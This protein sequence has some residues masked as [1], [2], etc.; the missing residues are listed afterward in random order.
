MP[1]VSSILLGV[2]AATAI[3]GTASSIAGASSASDMQQ[4]AL[5]SQE[6]IQAAQVRLAQQ[7]DAR[8]SELH[9]FWKSNYADIEKEMADYLEGGPGNAWIETAKE[10]VPTIHRVSENV[11]DA[12]VLDMAGRGIEADANGVYGTTLSSIDRGKAAEIASAIN[13]AKREGKT[14]WL[15]AASNLASIGR[16]LN[17]AGI[18]AGAS[19]QSGMQGAALTGSNILNNATSTANQ[20]WG[21]VQQGVQGVLNLPW[22]KWTSSGPGATTTTQ[23]LQA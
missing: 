20:A 16:G 8:A 14:E 5:D 15:Q 6:A 1:A 10:E 3:A 18:N 7:Q 9:E 2:G 17:S 11:K 4:K 22:D 12:A 13:R 23:V 21:G 19:A